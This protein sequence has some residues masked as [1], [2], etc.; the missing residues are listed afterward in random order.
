MSNKFSHLDT[1]RVILEIVQHFRLKRE[2]DAAAKTYEGEG[3]N[4]AHFDR[5]HPTSNP[6]QDE[7][8]WILEA[9]KEVPE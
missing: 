7:R 8:E 4:V 6:R 9:T 1:R 2:R 3:F 5:W